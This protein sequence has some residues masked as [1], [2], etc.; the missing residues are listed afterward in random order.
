[1][2]FQDN[3]LANKDRQYW[4][5]VASDGSI[6][7]PRVAA[8]TYRLTVYGVGIF[9]EYT[10]DD[11]VVRA[12][13]T[14][15]TEATWT[16]ESA[17]TELWRIGTPDRSSGDF[18]HGD[19]RDETRTNK[20]EQHRLYWAVHDFPDDFPEGVSFHV[21]ESDPQRDFNYIQWSVFGG[22][23]NAIRPDPYYDN[24]V[25]V[26]NITFDVTAEQLEGK[27]V[28]TFTVQLAGVK[29][30]A[31]NLDSASKPFADLDYTVIVNG[32]PLPVWTIP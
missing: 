16:A 31:G 22:K 17:G 8:G 13:D 15:T 12:G 27:T 26:W 6:T 21:G 10:Q 25:N 3:N 2:D 28:A 30:S 9:G 7:I 4:G 32:Q 29:T 14:T 20:P 1:M 23:G 19:E 11:V 24:T 18:R 5:E